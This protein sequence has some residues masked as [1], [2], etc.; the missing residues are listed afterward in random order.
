MTWGKTNGCVRTHVQATSDAGTGQWLLLCVLLTRLNETW[1]L[2]LGQLNL[3]SAKGGE[4]DVCHLCM[5]GS[6]R[7]DG[8]NGRRRVCGGDHADLVVPGWLAHLD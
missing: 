6:A 8:V 3:S 2:L 5:A 4:V 7:V 1:H